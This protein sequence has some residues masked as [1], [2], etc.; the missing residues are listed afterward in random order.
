MIA[1]P[2]ILFALA[3]AIPLFVPSHAAAAP[4][5][6]GAASP[7]QA[8]Q[9]VI[10]PFYQRSAENQACNAVEGKLSACPLT[11]RLRKSLALE[12]QYEKRHFHGG[13]GNWFCRCQSAPR[14]VTINSVIRQGVTW[15]VFTT[16][17][18]DGITQK[19]T[20]IARHKSDGWRIANE[21]CTARPWRDMY[22][23][24]IGPC[25]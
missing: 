10:R 11:G 16:W 20:F 8:V 1:R 22:H 9:T 12:L 7:R 5:S 13:T 4:Q 21:F 2:S 23:R 18:W 6:S 3:L 14:Q 19:L 17:H 24:P 25:Y 15:R